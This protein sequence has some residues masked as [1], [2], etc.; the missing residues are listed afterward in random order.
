VLAAVNRA[1][2]TALDQLFDE[3]FFGERLSQQRIIYVLKNLC[4]KVHRELVSEYSLPQTGQTLFDN[5][6]FLLDASV[7]YCFA[8]S[9]DGVSKMEDQC[10]YEVSTIRVS[11]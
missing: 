8:T 10:K 4:I 5:L 2:A 9:K 3:I 7:T 11:G 1:H 6:S